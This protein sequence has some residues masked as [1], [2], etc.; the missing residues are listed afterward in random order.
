[1]SNL[2]IH[3]TVK[4]IVKPN[5]LNLMVYKMTKNNKTL[6]KKY[7]R[8]FFLFDNIRQYQLMTIS[9]FSYI[10]IHK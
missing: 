8:S 3:L 7:S 2:K 4:S 6:I 1:M 9:L 5:S 10:C